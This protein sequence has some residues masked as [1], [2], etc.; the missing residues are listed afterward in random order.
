MNDQLVSII[1]IT[2]NSEKYVQ[3]TLDSIKFQTYV[4]IELIVSDDCSSDATVEICKQWIDKN[5]KRFARTELIKS[6]TNTGISEN[7]NRGVKISKGAWIKI[8]AGDDIL[9]KECIQRYM[10]HIVNEKK[11]IDFVYSSVNHIDAYGNVIKYNSKIEW[12]YSFNKLNPV[13][14]LETLIHK[15]KVWAA[16]WM[17]SRN[18]YEIIGGYDERYKCYE[19]RPFLINVVRHGFKIHFLDMVGALYRVHNDSVQRTN[20]IL[21]CYEESKMNYYIKEINNNLKINN[22][23]KIYIELR[24]KQ[25]L[26]F[27]FNNKVNAVSSLILKILSRLTIR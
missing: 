7:C 26:K 16:T 15:N 21:N 11:I 23:I 27:V 13:Q 19:D 14:Q 20:Y 24:T 8:I 10:R 25:I 1:I 2:Y 6:N 4:N 3:Q 12:Q 22:L 9:S 5:K 17:F 18:L